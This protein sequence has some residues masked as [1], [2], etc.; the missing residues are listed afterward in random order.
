MPVLFWPYTGPKKQKLTRSNVASNFLWPMENKIINEKDVRVNAGFE[1][2]SLMTFCLMVIVMI[3]FEY[4][5][6]PKTPECRSQWPGSWLKVL[7]QYALRIVNLT[8]RNWVVIVIVRNR[9]NESELLGFVG[10]VG[11]QR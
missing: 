6:G 11:G 1:S 10:S 7:F 5:V 3:H 8:L 9:H 4:P 2:V